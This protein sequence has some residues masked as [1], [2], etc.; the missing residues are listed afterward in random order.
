[1]DYGSK[2]FKILFYKDFTDT[3]PLV[4]HCL[5]GYCMNLE[6]YDIH[7]SYSGLKSTNIKIW[8]GN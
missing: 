8:G 1:M 5:C 6:Y 2:L 4:K 3:K 7:G